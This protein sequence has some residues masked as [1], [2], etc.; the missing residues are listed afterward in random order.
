MYNGALANAGLSTDPFTGSQYAFGDGNPVSNIELDGHT[1]VDPGGGGGTGGLTQQQMSAMEG[2]INSLAKN[3]L[4]APRPTT[5]D[6]MAATANHLA[7]A[8]DALAFLTADIPFVDVGTTIVAG[9][10]NASAGVF[11]T[12]QG[13]Q[14]I[15][16][17]DYLGGAGDIASG[18]FPFLPLGKL[19]GQG[20]STIANKLTSDAADESSPVLAAAKAEAN[21]LSS[22]SNKSRPAVAEALQL[23]SGKIYSSGS[24]RG[25]P[26]VLHPDVQAIL[27]DI[28]EDERG[29]GHGSCGLA[30]CVS[31]ALNNGFNPTG[32]SAAAVL[33]RG[34]TENPMHGTSVGPC[35]SCVALEDAFDLIFEGI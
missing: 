29:A 32:S 11:D 17:G 6:K 19:G 13:I 2:A 16:N 3:V 5:I 20:I 28:P 10:L 14:A 8:G 21:S 25:V 35:D 12:A 22:L 18:V 31:D 9:G 27:N 4:A 30:V 33:V 23:P 1:I 34:S 24:V 7:I 15:S 26:P